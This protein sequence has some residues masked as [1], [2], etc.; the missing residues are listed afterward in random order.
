MVDAAAERSVGEYGTEPRGFV[1]AWG[2]SCGFS[3]IL[4]FAVRFLSC[5][6]WLCSNFY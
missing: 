4:L 5:A 2:V 6:L 3:L 1:A